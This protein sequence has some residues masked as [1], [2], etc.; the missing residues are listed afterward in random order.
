MPP[1]QD[2]GFVGADANEEHYSGDTLTAMKTLSA[3]S[4]YL[5][6]MVGQD[7]GSSLGTYSGTI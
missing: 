7:G 1:L 6:F 3:G 5:V 4:H 2:G